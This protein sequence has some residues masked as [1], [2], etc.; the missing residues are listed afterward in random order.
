MAPGG[1]QELPHPA[2]LCLAVWGESRAEL[3]RYA[4]L[5]L[6]EA[7]DCWV[8]PERQAAT[9]EIHLHAPD[10]E[11]LLVDW[12]GELLYQGERQQACWQTCTLHHL[13]ATELQA[14]VQGV[15][16]ARPRREVKAVTYAGLEVVEEAQGR[17]TATITLDV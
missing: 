12:L 2:D 16:P 11:T 8:A 3:Y 13:S 15:R 17:W 6:F 1:F 14:T 5:A 10:P 9:S 4:A 7:L